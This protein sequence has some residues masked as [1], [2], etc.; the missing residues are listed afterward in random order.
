MNLLVR[1]EIAVV[2][3]DATFERVLNIYPE[4]ELA[5]KPAFAVALQN[6]QIEFKTLMDEAGRIL[7]PWQMFFLDPTNLDAELSRIERLR[8]RASRRL[9]SK[10]RGSGSITSKRILDRLV[11]CQTYLSENHANK[12][13]NRFCGSLKRQS[14]ADA[15]L[16]MLEHFAIDMD[17]FRRKNK[18]DALA[19]LVEKIEGGAVN[20]CQGVLTNKILPHL[21]A[22]RSVYKNTSGFV[23][24]DEHFPFAFIPS[25]IN[26]DEREGRQIFTLAFLVAL[27]GLDA[28]EYQMEQDF[29]VSLLKARGLRRKAYDIVTELLLPFGHTALLEGAPITFETRDHLSRRYKLT[30]TAVVVI[31]KKRGLI[32]TAE[33]EDLL[34]TPTPGGGKSVARTP[35]ID[36]SVRKFNGKYAFEYINADFASQ[37]VTA[38]Q[39]Q[40][41]L[42]G[43]IN[44]KGF[45]Q[46]KAK[47]G[48]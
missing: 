23:I 32:S 17:A 34:P 7:I 30:P 37:K 33:Y 2:L 44:K 11:R 1:S 19:Y 45:K 14:V 25:E 31:L 26:P 27:I 47:L 39:M 21:K 41:L 29:K 28:Y 18:R 38:V 6:G 12:S 3:D 22:S 4:E 40:Y 24:H 16:T 13:S 35:S 43:A 46:Y 9:L 42:F 48:L 20:V 10:R 5:K 36:L 15:V 8:H